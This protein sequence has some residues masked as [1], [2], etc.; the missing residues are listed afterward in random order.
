MISAALDAEIEQIVMANDTQY[1]ARPRFCTSHVFESKRRKNKI[2]ESFISPQAGKSAALLSPHNSVMLLCKYHYFNA[3]KDQCPCVRVI[4]NTKKQ[5]VGKQI[6]DLV[7]SSL[8]P[9]APQRDHEKRAN[10]VSKEVI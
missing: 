2:N 6:S 7:F 3:N 4:C 1:L 8:L 10:G 9:V 5:R